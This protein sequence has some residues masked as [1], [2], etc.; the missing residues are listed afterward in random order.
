MKK[1]KN[2]KIIFLLTTFFIGCFG[3]GLVA[4]KIIKHISPSSLALSGADKTAMVITACVSLF[5]SYL[6]II[7]HEAGHLVFGLLS[8][9]KYL[10]FR[11]GSLTL[12]KRN[13]KFEFKKMS[14][15]GTA[16]QCVL[17]PP[18]SKEPEK[19]PF[20]LYHAGGGIFNILTALITFPIAF[21]INGII[22]RTFLWVL[23]AI[24]LVIGFT[25]LIPMIIQVPN[26]GYNIMGISKNPLY[27]SQ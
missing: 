6:L 8:G 26:D 1:K 12:I 15:K 10:L 22:I 13:N 14:I 5:I 11:V 21:S 4:G 20:F 18:E 23:G 9:Y 16:G 2:Q 17:M 25:N 7:I 27:K 24:S 3:G 19:V